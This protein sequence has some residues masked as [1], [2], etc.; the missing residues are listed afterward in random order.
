MDNEIKEEQKHFHKVIEAFA[1]YRKHSSSILNYKIKNLQVIPIHLREKMIARLTKHTECININSYLFHRII[2]EH[3]VFIEKQEDLQLDPISEQDH[4]KVR[5][6]LKQI[7]R[8]WT[9]DGEVERNQTYLP[10]LQLLEELYGDIP[11]EKRGDIKVLCPGAGLGRLVFE[12]VKKGFSS[13]G[14][15]FSFYMLLASNFILNQIEKPHSVTIYPYIH[16][17]SNMPSAD[18]QTKALTFPDVQIFNSFPKSADFSMV[19]GDFTEVYTEKHQESAWDVVVTC[20]F[21]DTAKNLIDYLKVLRYCLKNGGKWINLGPLLYHFE[22]SD[23]SFEYT[24]EEFK[25][26]AEAYGFSIRKESKIDSTYSACQESMI[27]YTYHN[28]F[29]MATL[30][31]D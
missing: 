20:Y 5:S 16:Q 10:I 29:F 18:I 17:F 6:T 4:D 19:A 21:M 12:I 30:N 8:D 2:E 27:H 15:E 14:N 22:G 31:K 9:T 24:L 28:C 7:V 13:Q 1:G 25:D 3:P 11:V 26:L 23:N